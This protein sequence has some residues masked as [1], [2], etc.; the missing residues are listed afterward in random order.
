MFK[1]YEKSFSA[2]IDTNQ[3][4][5]NDEMALGMLDIF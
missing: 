5:N 4:D 1:F 2:I 3:N